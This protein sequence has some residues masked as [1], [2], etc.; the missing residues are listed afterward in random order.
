MT[1]QIFI[2]FAVCFILRGRDTLIDFL[3]F[4]S[5]RHD[6]RLFTVLYF[7]VR[8]SRS[9]ALRYGLPILHECQNYLGGRGISK[10]SHEKIGDV[11]SLASFALCCES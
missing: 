5:S 8:S 6:F 3:R 4:I 7:S 9:R 11:T 2:N 10:R 1:E